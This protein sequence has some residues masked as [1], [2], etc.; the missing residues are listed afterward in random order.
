MLARRR[1]EA[2]RERQ[3]HIYRP[4]ER[5]RL[6]RPSMRIVI[7]TDEYVPVGFD[8][9]VAQFLR[10]RDLGRHRR[11]GRLGPDLLAWFAALANCCAPTWPSSRCPACQH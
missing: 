10:A 11:L 7:A 5:W 9:P 2:G 8:V 4:G 1:N 3:W 6:P